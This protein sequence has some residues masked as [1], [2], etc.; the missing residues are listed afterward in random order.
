MS[1]H[2]QNSIQIRHQFIRLKIKHQMYQYVRYTRG[3]I[4][5]S[6][7]SDSQTIRR[8]NHLKVILQEI[9]RQNDNKYK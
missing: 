7:L 8:V 9:R 6:V 4:T 1:I 2:L 3:I 5:M